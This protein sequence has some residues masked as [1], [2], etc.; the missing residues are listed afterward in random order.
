MTAF[1]TRDRRTDD[2][3]FWLYYVSSDVWLKATEPQCRCLLPRNRVRS[4]YLHS[5]PPRLTVLHQLSKEKKRKKKRDSPVG[6]ICTRTSD[7]RSRSANRRADSVRAELT[8]L[9]ESAEYKQTATVGAFLPS[10]FGAFKKMERS[11]GG[12]DGNWSHRDIV[13]P[14]R[15]RTNGLGVAECRRA[16]LCFSLC[17]TAFLFH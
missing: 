2:P 16:C 3:Y 6:D 7:K 11:R 9:V 5:N 4:A 8:A 12:G 17:V 1:I 14:L 15:I 13:L 10:R